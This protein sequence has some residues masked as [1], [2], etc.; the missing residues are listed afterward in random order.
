[1]QILCG[2]GLF[3]TSHYVGGTIDGGMILFIHLMGHIINKL[4]INPEHIKF[5]KDSISLFRWQVLSN[6]ETPAIIKGVNNDTMIV[7]NNISNSNQNLYLPLSTILESRG[8]R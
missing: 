1:M 8:F 2:S 7:N 6:K 3:R 4:H 5:Y